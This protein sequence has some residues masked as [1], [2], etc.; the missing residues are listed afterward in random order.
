MGFNEHI[1]FISSLQAS[2]IHGAQAVT[3]VETGR[4]LDLMLR[5]HNANVIRTRVGDA[6]VANEVKNTNSCI[7]VEQVGVYI[8][9]EMGFYPDSIFATLY[10]LSNID[11]VSQ[12]REKIEE[13][14][15]LFFD[16][17]SIGC[18]EHDKRAIMHCL[19]RRLEY[20]DYEEVNMIDGVRFEFKDSWVLIR[21]S[22]TEP[23]IRVLCES[24][25]ERR[26]KELLEKARGLVESCKP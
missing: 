13:Y 10:L 7:G 9:P 18:R 6:F 14:P 23:I 15:K 11:R 12:I 17:S 8:L 3:T 16:K 24:E 4:L 19:S 25:N 20:F 2:K 5:D 21:P 22:G 26:M 1:S